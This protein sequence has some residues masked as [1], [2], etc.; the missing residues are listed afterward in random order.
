MI[1]YTI[2]EMERTFYPVGQGA[3]YRERFILED[4]SVFNIVYDCGTINRKKQI[5]SNIIDNEFQEDIDILFISHFHDDHISNV[6]EL[7]DK[8]HPKMIVMPYLT[9][10]D[11]SYEKFYVLYNSLKTG[12]KRINELVDR[13]SLVDKQVEL[14]KQSNVKEIYL[15]SKEK[16][17]Q[18]DDRVSIVAEG[19]LSKT[20]NTKI[21]DKIKDYWIFD[22]FVS[23]D[24]RRSI[25][26][27]EFKKIMGA[28]IY[29]LMLDPL[30]LNE[31]LSNED[32]ITKIKEIYKNNCKDLNETSLVLYSGTINSDSNLY[33]RC[34]MISYEK[35]NG[36]LYTGD[37]NAGNIN[38]YNELSNHFINYYDNIGCLQLPHHGSNDSFNDSFLNLNCVYVACVGEI[39]G[40]KHPGY[41][42]VNKIL[43]NRKH[44]YVVTDNSV[45]LVFTIK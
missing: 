6:F 42:V 5:I 4:D 38:N 23:S 12:T 30:K 3:F 36:C 44:L 37:Y 35:N 29:D 1:N 32:N 9:D 11:K 24:I 10:I 45:K 26:V 39:N 8:K 31:L 2:K 43:G 7:I 22:S 17:D 18:Y 20:T 40:F 28:N 15:V 27:D 33:A 25:I 21:L 41:K 14:F 34:P 16:N 13:I 19:S